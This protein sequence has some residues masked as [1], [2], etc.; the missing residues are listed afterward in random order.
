MRRLSQR[1]NWDT[2]SNRSISSRLIEAGYFHD[3]PRYWSINRRPAFVRHTLCPSRTKI[4]P[5][6]SA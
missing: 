2:T 5:L 4:H 6:S 3:R 1:S